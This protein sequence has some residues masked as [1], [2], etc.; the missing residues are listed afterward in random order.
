MAEAAD[1]PQRRL[2]EPSARELLTAVASTLRDLEA[3]PGSTMAE[4][5]QALVGEAAEFFGAEAR[6][7]GLWQ[8]IP[9]AE[10]AALLDAD[11]ACEVDT[12][13]RR[14]L[15]EATATALFAVTL[16][17]TISRRIARLFAAGDPAGGYILDRIA[18]QAADELAQV[19]ARD[20][21]SASAAAPGA[22]V[23]PYSPGYCGWNVAGQRSLF[24][25]LEPGEIGISLN[26]S[27]LMQPLKSVSGALVLAPLAAHDVGPAFPCCAGCATLDCRERVAMLRARLAAG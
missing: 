18:S 24:A 5:L 25:A 8:R 7:R 21:E 2:L 9:E 12:P 26:D 13:L 10:L 4:R 20:F 17:E 15:E 19:A 22:A 14:V 23:L 16:G 11:G 3:G 27:F 1:R 6:P